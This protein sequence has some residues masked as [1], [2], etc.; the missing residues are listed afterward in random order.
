MQNNAILGEKYG[1]LTVIEQPER[2]NGR[3][4]CKCICECGNTV[5]KRMDG[6]KSGNTRSCGCLG[7]ETRQKNRNVF[8]RKYNDYVIKGNI[9]EMYTTSGYSFIVDTDDFYR[10]KNGNWFSDKAGYIEG[11]INKQKIKLHRFITNCPDGLEVDH[12]NHDKSDN[13]KENLRIVN[14]SQNNMNHSVR[15]NSR[16]KVAGV[17]WYER[18]NAWQASITVNKQC[19]YLGR[20]KDLE[21]AIQVRKEA[22][23]KYFGEY[24][25][26]E[27][28]NE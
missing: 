26:K 24:A 23:K 25:Y 3:T 8:K 28:A 13:R 14:R 22:E 17:T 27:N 19:I 7:D 12:I 11:R 1:R 20:Y 4:Y 15:Q 2:I 18:Y 5:L 10:I 6:L 21:K 9:T 16:S